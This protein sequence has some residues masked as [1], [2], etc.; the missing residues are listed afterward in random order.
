M[1]YLVT[2]LRNTTAEVYVN[3][4]CLELNKL[5]TVLAAQIEIPGRFVLI[6]PSHR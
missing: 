1:I 6:A 2:S 4:L 3:D 5:V